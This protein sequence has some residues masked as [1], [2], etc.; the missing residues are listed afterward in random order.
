MKI[1]VNYNYEKKSTSRENSC[2]I[3][4][5]YFGKRH[6]TV[7][8]IKPTNVANLQ[9]NYFSSFIVDCTLKTV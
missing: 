9:N 4:T 1:K 2:N 6:E 3:L 8:L 7:R 5:S